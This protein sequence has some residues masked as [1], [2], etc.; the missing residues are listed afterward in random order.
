MSDL[1]TDRAKILPLLVV[2]V[3]IAVGATLVILLT[4]GPGGSS[5]STTSRPRAGS[6]T[7][8]IA[9]A[10]FAYR[11]TTLTVEKGAKVAWTDQDSANH[12][13]TGKG[14]D[15]GS[16][17]KGETRSVT[18]KRSGTYKYICQFHPFMHGTIVVR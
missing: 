11:P 2:M 14:F 13:A 16:I 5:A 9:I 3:V 18:F 1:L 4:P 10:N 8:K 15:T 7:T 6:T 12:T 17:N